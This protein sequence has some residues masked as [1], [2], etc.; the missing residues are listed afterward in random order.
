MGS[1]L[2]TSELTVVLLTIRFGVLLGQAQL[3]GPAL[4]ALWMVVTAKANQAE[5]FGVG[6]A[7]FRGRVNADEPAR[8]H[9]T[10]PKS[11]ERATQEEYANEWR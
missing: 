2:M 11:P 5:R 7:E 8:V 9:A 6:L 1:D 3:L 4:R 10:F